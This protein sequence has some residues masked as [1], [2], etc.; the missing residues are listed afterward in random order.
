[1]T[2]LPCQQPP[3]A[4]A[5]TGQQSRGEQR[6]HARQTAA[7]Y[8]T[9][10]ERGADVTAAVVSSA[11]SAVSPPR[12]KLPLARTTAHSTRCLS[13]CGSTERSTAALCGSSRP[14]YA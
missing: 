13:F 6:V 5:F 14:R 1:M 7:V 8:A 12:V 4:V 11:L 2:A 9:A 3:R 10:A